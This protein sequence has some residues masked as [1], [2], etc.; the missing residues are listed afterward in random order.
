MKRR[1]VLTGAAALAVGTVLLRPRDHSAGYTPYFDGLNRYLR[2]QGPGHP[3]LLIDQHRLVHN[4]TALLALLP[5]DRALRIVAKSLPSIGLLD[6]VMRLTATRKVMVFHQPFMTALVTQRPDSDLLLGKPMPVNAAAQFYR[7]LPANSP[8]EPAQQLQWLID[9]EARLR[10]YLDLARQLRRRLRI[11]IEIDIGLRRGGLDTIE[12]LDALLDIINSNPDHLQFSGFMGYDAHVG[13]QPALVE[14]AE[15]SYQRSQDRY[16]AFIDRLYAHSP[17]YRDQTLTFNG[18]G[19]ATVAFHDDNTVLNDLA[20]GSCLV[21]PSD[22]D[23]P[24]LADFQPAAFIAAP[25]LKQAEGLDLP[26]PLPLGKI[27][28][29]WNPN[30]R[31]TWFIYGGF[32]KATPVAPEGISANALYGASSNQMM[33]NGSNQLHLS[34]DD[35]LF[36][37]P[38]QSEAVLLEFGDLA[39]WDGAQIQQRWPVLTDPTTGA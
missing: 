38:H 28:S 5:K 31:Q 16:Q 30:R 27:W 10:Q 39:V 25:V 20:A 6:Q 8:F 9:S 2:R 19:S 24:G 1:H 22:F 21:K 29:L 18:A 37:R 7:Q 33:F 4:C 34:V 17:Q 15:T 23:V 35:H 14:S 11:N 3:L 13:K 32:W 12:H 36:L 26:G